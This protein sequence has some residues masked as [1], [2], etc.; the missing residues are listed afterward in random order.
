M[1]E[2][3]PD[4]RRALLL[5]LRLGGY[6]PEE[7]GSGEDALDQI[8]QNSAI[9]GAIDAVVLD[10]RLPGM[11]GLQVLTKLRHQMST[12]TLPVVLIS[13][14]ASIPNSV[15]SDE[16]ASFVAKPFHPDQLLERLDEMLT[17]RTEERR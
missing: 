12:Q 1:V 11:D 4:H 15:Q 2:D 8:G 6:R 13:A 9:P 14:H 17:G 3:D 10:V 7:C 5:T 16:Y